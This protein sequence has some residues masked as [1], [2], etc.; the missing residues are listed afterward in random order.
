MLPPYFAI[1]GADRCLTAAETARAAGTSPDDAG[2]RAAWTLYQEQFG[3][4]C[5]TTLDP[6]FHALAH[7]ARW[8]GV[9]AIPVD[10]PVLVV[11][12]GPSARAAMPEL[13]RHRANVR[14]FT[15]PRGA[16]L[17]AEHGLRPDL[18]IVEHRTALDAQHSAQLRADGGPDAL[19]DA[20]LVAAEW[21]TPASLLTGVAAD[22]LF[23]PDPCPTWGWWPATAAALAIDGGA[24]RVGLL[25]IDLGAAGRP[26]PAFDS[27]AQ[28]LTLIARVGGAEAMDCGAIGARKPG[29]TLAPLDA[30]AVGRCAGPLRLERRMA[31]PPDAL[32]DTLILRQRALTPLVERARRIHAVGLDARR[33]AKTQALD[34]LVAEM[35]AWGQDPAIRLDVQEG[36][37]VSFLPRLWRTGVDAGLGRQLWRPLVLALDEVVAQAT[38][39]DGLLRMEAA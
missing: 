20:P 23:V 36:L 11:G 30:L 4:F 37:G 33:G 16:A 3:G 38:R 34:G 14:V 12:S 1:I 25:G 27:L 32:V 26:D 39:L 19:R 28:L 10:E 5:E 8:R 13:A 17:L 21:R 6:Q 24:A 18:V 9:V 7:P 15:S 35:L 2:L 29:W 31:P 22:R